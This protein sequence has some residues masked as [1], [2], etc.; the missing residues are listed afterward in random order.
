MATLT[1]YMF[2]IGSYLY[3][4][5]LQTSEICDALKRVECVTDT[6]R[7]I[8]I[9]SITYYVVSLYIL[10]YKVFR[11]CDHNTYTTVEINIM[12]IE[13]CLGYSF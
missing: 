12:T 5:I 4:Y 7:G 10:Y 2:M 3:R 8:G 11:I 9:Y 1:L 6:L 13:V